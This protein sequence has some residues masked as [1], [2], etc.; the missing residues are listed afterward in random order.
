MPDES[1]LDSAGDV[2]VAIVAYRTPVVLAD[3][4]ASFVRHRPA[5]VLEVIVIDNS[6]DGS[7]R[8]LE[9]EFPWVTWVENAE[10]VHFRRGVNQAARLATG[11][12][13]LLLNPDA[14]LTDGHA[15]AQLAEVLDRE[16]GVG[17]VGPKIRGDDGRLAPQGE[18]LPGLGRLFAQK[19]YLDALWPGNPLARHYRRDGVSRE[20]SGPV[21][22]L[23]AA[24]LLCRREEFLA[25]GGFDERAVAYC[26]EPELAARMRRCGLGAYYLAEA[27]VYHRWREGGTRLEGQADRD[28]YFRTA[29][30]LYYRENYGVA[31]GLLFDGLDGVQGGIRRLAR[32]VR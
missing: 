17:L 8:P 29:Q 25:V 32:A 22:T 27:F 20:E 4:L 12:Y 6:A 24:V 3:C 31:G 21:E 28:G 11:H 7:V 13:L 9:V 18:R 16:P 23:A 10:N 26:E 14:Y 30:R 1:P 2:S 5:R 15:I 19:L